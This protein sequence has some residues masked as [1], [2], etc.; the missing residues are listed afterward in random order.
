MNPDVR[1]RLAIDREL[2]GDFHVGIVKGFKLFFPIR[3][4]EFEKQRAQD[5]RCIQ[6]SI[7]DRCHTRRIHLGTGLAWLATTEAAGSTRAAA[8]RTAW[9]PTTRA[10]WTSGRTEAAR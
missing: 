9:S 8:A 3:I 2:G 5:I 6:R 1:I 7:G 4:F 10:T